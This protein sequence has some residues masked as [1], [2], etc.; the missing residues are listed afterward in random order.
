VQPVTITPSIPTSITSTLPITQ[1]TLVQPSVNNGIDNLWDDTVADEEFL[2]VK[3]DFENPSK[4][5]R[6]YFYMGVFLLT[7]Y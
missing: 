7:K 4:K 1:A 5:I 2:N 3:E 6:Y